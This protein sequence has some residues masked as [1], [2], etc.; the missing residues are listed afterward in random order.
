LIGKGTAKAGDKVGNDI[1]KQEEEIESKNKKLRDLLNCVRNFKGLVIL[2]EEDK[3]VNSDESFENLEK[4]S[5][6]V[7]SIMMR[8]MVR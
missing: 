6:V 1:I 3:T 7:C 2:E 8:I 4:K 5:A